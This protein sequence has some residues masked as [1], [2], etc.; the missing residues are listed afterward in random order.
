MRLRAGLVV[1]AIALAASACGPKRVAE[2]VVTAPHFPDYVKPTVP[3]A[4][5]GSRAIT[6]QER[7]WLFLQAGD[8]RNAD[9]E[10]AEAL[11]AAPDFYP[12]EAT[13]GYVELARKESRSALIHF[14]RA[15]TRQ[16]NYAPAL[17]G[18]GETL[19][20]LGRDAEAVDAFQAAL[21]ADRTLVDLP[22]RIDVVKFR[23]VQQDVATA[24]QAARAGRS[25]DA[26]R[27]YRAAIGRSPETAFL[28]REVA[29]V[30]RDRGDQDAALQDLRKA[31]VLDPADA[32][33]LSL[34]GDILSARG[35][36]DAAVKAYSDALAIE[37]DTTIEAKRNAIRART[38]AARLPAEYQAIATAPQITRGDLAALIGV[39]LPSL[40]DG[41]RA[42]DVGVITDIRRHWAE[43]WILSVTRAG[44]LD[45]FENHAFQPRTIVRRVDFAQA[46]S[47]LLAQ[48]AVVVPAQGQRWANARGRFSDI[49]AGH[50]AYPAASVA[51]AAGVMA[52]GTDGA[53]QP[54][55]PVTGGEAVDALETVRRMLPAA[56]NRRR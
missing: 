35:E 38:E 34:L 10:I 14:D 53:F 25:D 4:L 5:A 3:A 23:V 7:A 33:A 28:Y 8:F 47:R 11:K 13:S 40:I 46:V 18:R 44:V 20:A 24:R 15:L 9:R 1:L 31:I 26:V 41:M 29:G 49:N 30:E 55:R 27:A 32:A 52:I 43:T 42:H 56:D 37:P 45:P 50:L 17:A 16:A 36:D 2:P 19:L 51:T 54:S 22:R 12:A 39:H 6:N 48:V 21:A